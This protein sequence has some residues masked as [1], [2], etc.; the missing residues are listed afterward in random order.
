[1]SG[2]HGIRIDL[3]TEAVTLLGETAQVAL[4]TIIRELV[5]QSIRRGPPGQI[6]IAV[7]ETGDGGIV[8]SVADDAEP[9]RRLRSLEAIEERVRQVHGTVEVVVGDGGTDVRVTL[10]PQPAT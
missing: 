4:Y 8:A 9:E 10:G 5:E 3:E 2:S 7:A 1:M 6:G